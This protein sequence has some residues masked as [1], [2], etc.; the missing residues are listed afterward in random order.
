MGLL[1]GFIA[2]IATT[3]FAQPL[4]KFYDL[5]AQAA[6]ALARFED[7]IDHG[8]EGEF[9]HRAQWIEERRLA[10]Q[11]CGSSLLAFATS[12]AL[13]A[14]WFYK[15]L[16]KRSRYYVRNAGFS[17]MTLAK[18]NPGTE[19]SERVRAQIV[20]AL[21]LKYGPAR[22]AKPGNKLLI[23]GI[24]GYVGTLLYLV[25]FARGYRQADA[26]GILGL[27][28]FIIGGIS[29]LLG[30]MAFWIGTITGTPLVSFTFGLSVMKRNWK[31]IVGST[32]LVASI[33]AV[34][35]AIEPRFLRM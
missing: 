33:L 23:V 32:L 15:L 2:W 12:N 26:I 22:Q 7:Q 27:S 6:E 34:L 3:F 11:A 25:S 1:G 5:R 14:S 28:P 13:V 8:V 17:L 16:P 19:A 24:I 21:K 10:Y 31:R 30:W 9:R 35:A 4:T 18:V 20:S 29:L